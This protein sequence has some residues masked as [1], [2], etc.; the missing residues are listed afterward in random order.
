MS[1]PILSSIES[2]FTHF[3]KYTKDRA[4]LFV[5]K[6]IDCIS[7]A[8]SFIIAGFFYAIL[9][10]LVFIFL[11]LGLALLIGELTGTFYLGFFIVAMFYF[12]LGIT[13][14][15]LRKKLLK[16]FIVN[17]FIKKLYKNEAKE[18]E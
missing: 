10:I 1:N 4:E 18:P 5:L 6:A 11:N 2:L 13:L 17:L 3:K 9:F 12:L 14:F 8:L 16:P 7:S 15:F